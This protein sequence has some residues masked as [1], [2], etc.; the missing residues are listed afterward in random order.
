MGKQ[1][2]MIDISLKHGESLTCHWKLKKHHWNINQI[3]WPFHG[4]V[5][6]RECPH[7]ETDHDRPTSIKM[8]YHGIRCIMICVT[9]EKSWLLSWSGNVMEISWNTT[10]DHKSFDLHGCVSNQ[11]KKITNL[12][13]DVG[14]LTSLRLC[15]YACDKQS[16][17]FIEGVYRPCLGIALKVSPNNSI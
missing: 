13:L 8:Q 1:R 6:V 12:S 10:S 15:G 14:S 5:G 2:N 16:V 9:L 3:S 4:H 17:E 11:R 7:F